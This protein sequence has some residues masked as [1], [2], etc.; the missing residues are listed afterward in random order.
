MNRLS[1]VKFNDWEVGSFYIYIASKYF[2]SS[3]R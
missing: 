2:F 3:S 1:K